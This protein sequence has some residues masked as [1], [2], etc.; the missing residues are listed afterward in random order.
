[1]GLALNLRSIVGQLLQLDIVGNGPQLK[2]NAGTMEMRNSTDTGFVITRGS[3]PVGN[4]DY[5]TKGTADLA[6]WR[7]VNPNWLVTDWYI[8]G[9]TGDDTASGT[10]IGSPIKTGAELMKRLGP[11]AM[12]P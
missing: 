8:D 3:D 6:Y 10:A 7:S 1:M 12:W 4:N 5:V 9:V 2:H 11:Y